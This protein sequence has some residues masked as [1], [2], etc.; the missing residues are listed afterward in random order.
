[1]REVLSYRPAQEASLYVCEDGISVWGD[2]HAIRVPIEDIQAVKRLSH[3]VAL[4]LKKSMLTV[5]SAP[6]A[7]EE[8]F[9]Q[10]MKLLQEAD[11]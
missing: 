6:L 10:L 9:E 5:P 11:F 4:Y 2:I 8:D 3:G 7:R 1:M